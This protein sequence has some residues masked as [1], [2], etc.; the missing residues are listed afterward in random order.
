MSLNPKLEVF[1]GHVVLLLRVG[2][3]KA[4]Q[5]LAVRSWSSDLALPWVMPVDISTYPS[6]MDTAT[7][8]RALLS[9]L[10]ECVSVSSNV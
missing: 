7:E 2:P 9:V 6:R 3:C 1:D 5:E 8:R 4:V 10:D